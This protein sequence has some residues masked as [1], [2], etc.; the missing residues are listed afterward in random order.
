V[1]STHTIKTLAP[2]DQNAVGS[3]PI[4]ITFDSNG[5]LW[6]ISQYGP[7]GSQVGNGTV[8]ELPVGLNTISLI[9]TFNST[10]GYT[11]VSAPVFGTS[12]NLYG[13]AELGGANQ[14]GTLFEIPGLG[15]TAAGAVAST[16]TPVDL[17]DLDNS[18]AGT[19]GDG[20]VTDSAGQSVDSATSTMSSLADDR[21]APAAVG[22]TGTVP[23]VIVFGPEFGKTGQATV[24]SSGGVDKLTP[25]FVEKQLQDYRQ[26]KQKLQDEQDAEDAYGVVLAAVGLSG[27]EIHTGPLASSEIQSQGIRSAAQSS[28]TAQLVAIKA[29]LK[30][31]AKELIVA[32]RDLKQQA[33]YVNPFN[34]I[35][36]TITSLTTQLA[37]QTNTAT[38]AKTQRKLT[39]EQ[40][41]QD[42]ILTEDTTAYNATATEEGLI[43]TQLNGIGTAIADLPPLVVAL[44]GSVAS[45]PKSA[46]PGK[47]AA[48]VVTVSH[49]GNN[50]AS[51]T[52]VTKLF[53]RPAGTTGDA[54][55][56]LPTVSVKIKIKPGVPSKEKLSITLPTTLPAGSYS[57]VVQLDP[58]NAFSESVL[59]SPIVG[60]QTFTVS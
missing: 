36:I 51:G 23:G 32:S 22:D 10:T 44:S 13:L 41:A 47:H 42:K 30:E 39:A 60:T 4:G 43:D 58:S 54:D 1:T 55:L 31:V 15:S 46:L 48:F 12:G 2:F 49:S 19:T 53:A 52:L 57:L 24:L 25:E 29:N 40:K 6:G 8:W 3:G 7:G 38:Q 50:L 56:A 35:G 9:S 33:S 14:D 26:Q 11:L 37:A 59:P 16:T 17:A 20:I 18:D 28:Y 34:S 5:N 21:L 27:S 45:V